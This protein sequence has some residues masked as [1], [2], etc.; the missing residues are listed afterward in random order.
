MENDHELHFFAFI[1]LAES[2]TINFKNV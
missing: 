1:F 2:K